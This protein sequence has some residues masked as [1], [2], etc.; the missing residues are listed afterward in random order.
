MMD[1]PDWE[2]GSSKQAV[3]KKKAAAAVVRY[4]QGESVCFGSS[5]DKERRRLQHVFQ[6]VS[7]KRIVAKLLQNLSLDSATDT[8]LIT[9]LAKVFD[10]QTYPSIQNKLSTQ[11]IHCGDFYDPNYNT[12]DCKNLCRLEHQV[13][14]AYKDGNTIGWECDECGESWI[15]E[16]GVTLDGGDI[17]EIGYC[18]EGPHSHGDQDD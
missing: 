14:R 16:W 4:A 17:E 3:K 5:L 1:D 12:L 8:T 9:S 15:R 10:E 7:E 6:Q 11:C 13:T 2:P 18:Y